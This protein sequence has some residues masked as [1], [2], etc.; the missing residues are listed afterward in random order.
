MNWQ[1]D[2]RATQETIQG[3]NVPRSFVLKGR[4][5]NGKEVW[6]HG[7]ATKHMEE[8]IVKYARGSTL[9]EGELMNSFI[10]DVDRLVPKAVPG[11]RMFFETP[12]WR[13]GIDTNDAVIFHALPR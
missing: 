6:V 13:I 12:F 10:A 7:H 5:V 1:D 8:S 9:Y 3:T 11:G 2:I 4:I